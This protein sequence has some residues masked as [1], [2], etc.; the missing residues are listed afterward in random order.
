VYDILRYTKK[1]TMT[2]EHALS[3]KP[4]CIYY[5]PKVQE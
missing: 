3:F 2:T 4:T 1:N 5:Y